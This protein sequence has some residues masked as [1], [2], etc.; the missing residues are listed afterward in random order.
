MGKDKDFSVFLKSRHVL[1]HFSYVVSSHLKAFG[2][3]RENK[4]HGKISFST[5]FQLLTSI[6]FQ[7]LVF[8]HLL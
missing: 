1:S 8:G 5:V 4:T 6:T 2:K 7:T 3:K